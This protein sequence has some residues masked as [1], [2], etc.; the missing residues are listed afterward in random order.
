MIRRSDLRVLS[1]ENR[2]R[3]P[4]ERLRHEAR[5]IRLAAGKGGKQP[6]RLHLPAVGRDAGDLDIRYGSRS[7]DL[8]T[9]QGLELHCVSSWVGRALQVE[10]GSNEAPTQHNSLSRSALV[11]ADARPNLHDRVLLCPR[12]GV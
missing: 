7:R 4:G 1:D 9:N 2:G 3:A 12:W 5:A 6:A 10:I 8:R 11:I